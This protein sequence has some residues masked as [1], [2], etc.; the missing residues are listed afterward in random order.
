M[1]ATPGSNR[2]MGTWPDGSHG[3]AHMLEHMCFQFLN[4]NIGRG[5]HRGTYK[6]TAVVAV[7]AAVVVIEIVVAAASSR[8][9]PMASARGARGTSKHY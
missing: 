5:R 6:T 4:N 3:G 1:L 2:E 8:A 9:K 7:T